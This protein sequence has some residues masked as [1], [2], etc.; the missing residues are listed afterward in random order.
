[1]DEI[2]ACPFPVFSFFPTNI[3][4]QT[5]GVERRFTEDHLHLVQGFQRSILGWR[6]CGAWWSLSCTTT[7]VLKDSHKHHKWTPN[8]PQIRSLVGHSNAQRRSAAATWLWQRHCWRRRFC[9]NSAGSS[10]DAPP[11]RVPKKNTGLVVC[12]G[13]IY[14]KIWKTPNVMVKTRKKTWCKPA[15]SCRDT[16]FHSKNHGK[17]QLFPGFPINQAI[18]R[19]DVF[20]GAGGCWKSSKI[21][22]SIHYDV[23][24]VGWNS[25]VPF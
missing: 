15:V 23:V 11:P 6:I 25:I 22:E 21:P 17:N 3:I 8:G 7:I 20:L 9:W 16:T 14:W 10:L 2:L 24:Q 5:K 13:R 1:M 12:W 18:E 4:I 19:K